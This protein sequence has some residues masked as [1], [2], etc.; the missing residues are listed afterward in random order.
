MAV[1]FPAPRHIQPRDLD[2]GLLDK[3]KHY[4]D[5]NEFCSLMLCDNIS[6]VCL[7][8]H[9]KITTLERYPRQHSS[10]Y[11]THMTGPVDYSSECQA[12]NHSTPSI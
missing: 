4:F 9:Y 7:F 5:N 8:L 3:C 11:P 1:L 12:N 2:S 10:A 6:K